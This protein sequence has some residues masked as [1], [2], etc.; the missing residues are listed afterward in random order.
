M[1]TKAI[2]LLVITDILLNFL[3]FVSFDAIE[4]DF[5]DTREGNWS[6][7][8]CDNIP[9]ESV[10]NSN[11]VNGLS[12]HESDTEDIG[13]IFRKLNEVRFIRMEFLQ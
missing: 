8:S 3:I 6:A 2:Q 5:S 13:D 11:N 1:M 4:A 7:N 9:S 12:R 10:N